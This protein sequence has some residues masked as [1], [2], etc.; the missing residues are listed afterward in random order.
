MYIWLSLSWFYISNHRYVYDNYETTFVISALIDHYLSHYFTKMVLSAGK[1]ITQWCSVCC[2][3][4]DFKH[5]YWQMLDWISTL[6]STLAQNC[7]H[8][9]FL[10]SQDVTFDIEDNN[11]SFYRFSTSTHLFSG[12][13]FPRQWEGIWFQSTV[14]PYISIE[15]SEM[16]SK[17]HCHIDK[18]GRKFIVKRYK[19]P[20]HFFVGDTILLS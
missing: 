10:Y 15:G 8:F 11:I 17:G 4:I 3:C 2:E 19:I 14:R 18:G 6:S 16:S 7:N 12:C 20:M 9:F 1:P 5:N 13:S